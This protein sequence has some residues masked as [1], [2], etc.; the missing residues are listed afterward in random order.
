MSFSYVSLFGE[1]Y[2]V[3]LLIMLILGLLSKFQPG[4]TLAPGT[5]NFTGQN[6]NSR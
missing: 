4:V 2:D 5:K 1:S 6:S 3:L